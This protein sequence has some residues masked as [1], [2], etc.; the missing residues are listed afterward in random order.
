MKQFLSYLTI[1]LAAATTSVASDDVTIFIPEITP[2]SKHSDGRQISPDIARWILARRLGWPGTSLRGD[3]DEEVLQGLDEFGGQQPVAF[4][5][6]N[7]KQPSHKLLVVLQ[8][9]DQAKDAQSKLGRVTVTEALPD[10]IE[11][12][13]LNG[14]L[15]EPSPR[16]PNS[17][18]CSYHW[19]WDPVVAADLV[20]RNTNGLDCPSEAPFLNEFKDAFSEERGDIESLRRVVQTH[21][22][23]TPFEPGQHVSAILRLSPQVQEK[24]V[25][26][27]R[28]LS[29][30]LTSAEASIVDTTVVV[31]P[32]NRWKS[33]S[34]SKSEP[35]IQSSGYSHRR[36]SSHL[37][38]MFPRDSNM[39][40]P[41]NTLSTLLPVCYATND[42]CTTRT[43]S[44][45]GHGYCY[46]KRQGAAKG[47][48]CYACKCLRTVDYT[49]PDK[50]TTK[51]IQWGGPACQ[52]KDV[53]MPFW[54][55]GGFSLLLVVGIWFAIG[56]LWQ[57][58]QEELPSVLSAGV[59][60][61][62]AQK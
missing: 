42:T 51:T 52:K 34:F 50:N 40:K 36:H 27:D 29:P 19:E 46:L 20:F 8:G 14:L 59:T 16:R 1:G 55:L 48:E 10:F 39:T 37:P 33:S 24:P 22:G 35:S 15:S 31:L 47:G 41:N 6:S 61:P 32:G 38:P 25:S 18:L 28:Y 21:F 3:I 11:A 23:G 2:A 53:S 45:S 49:D 17:R 54:L 56:L 62:R 44:C 13:F 4:G 60:A 5:D 26:S 9:F 57:M 58:G 7:L 43:N 12:S 30:I